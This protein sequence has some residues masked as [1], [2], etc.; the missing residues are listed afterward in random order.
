MDKVHIDVRE[1][2]IDDL[3]G[4]YHMGEQLFTLKDFPN[5]Y[6]TWDEYG[7]VALFQSEPEF[8]LVADI[9]GELAGFALGYIIEK[10]RVPWNY[11]HLVWLGVDKKFQRFG[12]ASKLLNEFREKMVSKNVRIMLIDTQADNEGAIKFFKKHG[13]SDPRAH[14]YMT[15]N[16][17]EAKT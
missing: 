5:L 6:R 4:V 7:V 15:L 2:T 14:V 10:P 1:M 8:S 16:L 11:G 9:E 12:V 17:N 13:F 3:S